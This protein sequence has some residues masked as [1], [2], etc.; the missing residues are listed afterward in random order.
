[1]DVYLD[2]SAPD[3]TPDWKCYDGQPGTVAD[4]V[5]YELSSTLEATFTEQKGS[6]GTALSVL[7]VTLDDSAREYVLAATLPLGGDV[8]TD[9]AAAKGLLSA[10]NEAFLVFRLRRDGAYAAWTLMSYM[11]YSKTDE[12]K[13]RFAVAKHRLFRRLGQSAFGQTREYYWDDLGDVDLYS[14]VA[15]FMCNRVIYPRG[16]G[17][18]PSRYDAALYSATVTYRVYNRLGNRMVSTAPYR[19]IV[20]VYANNGH[21]TNDSGW[22]PATGDELETT[23]EFSHTFYDLVLSRG[24]Q[25]TVRLMHVVR[26]SESYYPDL[27]VQFSAITTAVQPASRSSVHGVG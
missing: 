25:L 17:A 9:F 22:L 1:M 4:P 26:Q 12:E 13:V 8:D 7:K 10:A 18:L 20:R 5:P 6:E 23:G 15:S 21:F 11:P 2:T 27:S 16:D 24:D 19:A 3:G 14:D